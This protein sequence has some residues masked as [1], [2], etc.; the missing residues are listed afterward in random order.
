MYSLPWG[1][2]PKDYKLGIQKKKG[3]LSQN[4]RYID[5]LAAFTGTHGRNVIAMMAKSIWG[6]VPSF[7]L[8]CRTSC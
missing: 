7:Y 4:G 2:A 6:S 5:E 1:N 8:S 3:A